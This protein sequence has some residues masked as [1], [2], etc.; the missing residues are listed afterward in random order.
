MFKPKSEYEKLKSMV[1]PMLVK[2]YRKIAKERGLAPTSKTSDKEIVE[3]YI[4]VETAFKNAAKERNEDIPQNYI[5]YI[6]FSFYQVYEGFQGNDLCEILFQSQIDYE[7]KNY[8][9]S[10]LPKK[11]CKELII[12]ET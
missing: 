4:R 2:A 3:I 1:G 9:K 8:H 5:N 10:G 12:F 7:I 11:F 6:V